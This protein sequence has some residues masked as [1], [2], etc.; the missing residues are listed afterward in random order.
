MIGEIITSP[1]LLSS[2]QAPNLTNSVYLT[3]TSTQTRCL[4]KTK[5]SK[6]I[7]YWGNGI[8]SCATCDGALFKRKKIIVV[9]GG[10]SAMEEANYLTKFSDVLL[11]HRGDSFRAS[12][13]MQHK[14]MNNPRIKIMFNTKI[15]ELI[16]DT[17]ESESNLTSVRVMTGTT[18]QVLPVD[19]LFYGLGLKPNSQ[20]FVG[21]LLTDQDG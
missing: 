21:Q 3:K 14:V 17:S 19:G 1:P 11:I 9:G 6:S 16:G 8:S 13:A 4:A 5:L 7:R 18:E 15:T 2:Q 12:K 10:D 20:L